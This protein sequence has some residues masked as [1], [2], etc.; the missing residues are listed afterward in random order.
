MLFSLEAPCPRP[1]PVPF[2]S[3]TTRTGYTSP[4]AGSSQPK[5]IPSA[6]ASHAAESVELLRMRRGHVDLML[7]VASDGRAL[8]EAA[9]RL[10][11][12]RIVAKRKADP[13]GSEVTWYNN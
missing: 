10:N 13:Y 2:C 6:E 8:F 12:E 7:A 4:S 9:Q 1:P 5:A 3:S 11:L